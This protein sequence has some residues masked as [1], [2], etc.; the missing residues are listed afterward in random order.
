MKSIFKTG[1]FTHTPCL[2]KV[3][4][5]DHGQITLCGKSGSS[6]LIP[7]AFLLCKSIVLMTL[8]SGVGQRGASG[9]IVWKRR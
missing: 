8:C 6:G 3:Q 2:G 1:L 9:L 7:D 5:R 4:R